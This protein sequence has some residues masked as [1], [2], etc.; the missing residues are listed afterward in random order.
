MLP[1]PT[2][3]DLFLKNFSIKEKENYYWKLIQKNKGASGDKLIFNGINK[4]N[5]K[6]ILLVKQIQI[7]D[8]NDANINEE[9]LIHILNEFYIPLKLKGKNYFPKNIY[10]C[11]SND[12]KYLY[13]IIKEDVIPLNYLITSKKFDCL[14]DNQLGKWIIYQITVSLFILHSSDIIHNDIKPTNILINS[15]GRA[16][17]YGFNSATFKGEECYEFTLSYASPEILIGI[18]KPDEK[19]DMW[20]LG[21]II[22]EFYLK[23]YLIFKK[24]NISDKKKQ[25]NFILSKYGIKDNITIDELKNILNNENNSYQIDKNILAPIKDKDAKDL[26]NNLLSLN[27]KN[28]FSAKEVLNSEYLKDFK[29]FENIISLNNIIEKPFYSKEICENKLNKNK[30]KEIIKK[31]ISN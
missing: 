23:T 7:D 9:D 10:G 14:K 20:G 30:F 18:T 25:L 19:M 4:N 21:V 15:E 17:L 3:P 22:L 8:D 12:E 5:S 6:D 31:I 26:I 2:V 13:L 27:S 11:L 29:E 28:R 1:K 16:S 24:E